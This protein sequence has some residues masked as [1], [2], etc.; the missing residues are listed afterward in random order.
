MDTRTLK[1][2]YSKLSQED[3]T[4]L[5]T[6]KVELGKVDDFNKIAARLKSG[7]NAVNKAA[8]EMMDDISEF[9]KL[10]IKL[11]N[12]F[13]KAD[14]FSEQVQDEIDDIQLVARQVADAAK[15]LGLNPKDLVD[16]NVIDIVA[17]LEDT[18]DTVRANSDY[19]KSIINL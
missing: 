6:Q 19:A 10:Q 5:E 15:E 7:Q 9:N 1:K 4:N 2:I 8:Q 16:M 17:D 3:K 18:I 12:S 11:K 14:S 13:S